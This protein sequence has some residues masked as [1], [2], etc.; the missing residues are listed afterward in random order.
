MMPKVLESF[1]L[2]PALDEMLEK[3]LQFTSLNYQFEHYN[4]DQRLA[5][6]VELAVFRIAQ[7]LINNVIKHAKASFVS[8]QLFKN[9]N[10]LI[11][12]VEDNGKGF[13][14]TI[15]GDVHGLLN[16]KS[17]LNTV[18]GQVNFESSPTAGTTVTMR[19]LVDNY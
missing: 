18:N 6:K 14:D 11:L 7:E 3:A 1:G 17:R 2:V 8:V 12:I 16:I 10:Q 4:L 5:Q 9:Q 15:S 13:T 19:V